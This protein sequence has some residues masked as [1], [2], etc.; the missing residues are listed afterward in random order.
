[1]KKTEMH[2]FIQMLYSVVIAVSFYQ[3]A[4]TVDGHL[5]FTTD[6]KAFWESIPKEQAFRGLLF[7]FTYIIAAH[8]WFSYHRSKDEDK[9]NF[10]AYIPQIFSLLFL[11]QMFVAANGAHFQEWYMFGFWYTVSNVGGAFVFNRKRALRST[12]IVKYISHFIVAIVGFILTANNYPATNNYFFY[13]VITII[14]VL[15]L[16]FF[17]DRKNRKIEIDDVAADHTKAEKAAIEISKSE[18]AKRDQEN[19]DNLRAI[20]E[21]IASEVKSAVAT[22]MNKAHSK[23]S[24]NKK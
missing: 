10:W 22:A 8:D 7:V 12:Y 18:Q 13:L 19:T 17:D 3:A 14:I 5:A 15:I 20:K 21:A 4:I 2:T 1:M 24:C 23:T 16:W 6:F 9:D 11:S